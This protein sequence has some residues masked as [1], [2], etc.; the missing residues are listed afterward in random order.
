MPH[1]WPEQTPSTSLWR[2][3]RTTLIFVALITSASFTAGLLGT[4]NLSILA[5]MRGTRSV[6]AILLSA[7]WFWIY[8]M[9][10]LA[11]CYYWNH[12]RSRALREVVSGALTVTSAVV[13]L[14]AAWLSLIYQAF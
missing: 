3:G 5:A 7:P 14:Y 4:P 13:V 1:K 10:C 9:T 6:L 2:T 8:A 12:L 11:T